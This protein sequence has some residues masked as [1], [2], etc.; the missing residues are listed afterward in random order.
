M[1]RP[2]STYGVRYDGPNGG[3][4]E[5]AVFVYGKWRVRLRFTLFFLV[6]TVLLHSLLG[7]FHH[8]LAPRDPYAEPE[9]RAVKVFLSGSGQESDGSVANRL[10]LFYWLGE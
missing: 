3:G 2:P 7:W 10:R 8:W 5:R 9:G 4:D 6:I 1:K